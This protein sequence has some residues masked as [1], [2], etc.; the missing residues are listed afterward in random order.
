MLSKLRAILTPKPLPDYDAQITELMQA[1]R[2]TIEAALDEAREEGRREG[3]KEAR[4]D[5]PPSAGGE[6]S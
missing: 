2:D 1:C 3:R 4:R 6:G 5:D